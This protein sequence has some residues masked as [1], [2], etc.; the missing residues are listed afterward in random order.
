MV[1]KPAAT[2]LAPAGRAAVPRAT[3]IADDMTAFSGRNACAAT[4]ANNAC[5]SSDD[6]RRASSEAG[7]TL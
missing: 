1:D 4:P 5:A 3:P 7:I 2:G 6:Q